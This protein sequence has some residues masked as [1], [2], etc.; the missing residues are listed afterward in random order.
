MPT[1]DDDSQV[2]LDL[3]NL[4]VILLAQPDADTAIDGMHKVAQVIADR[5]MS[6]RAQLEAEAKRCA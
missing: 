6:I 4:L 2:I 1:I 5:A 3:A